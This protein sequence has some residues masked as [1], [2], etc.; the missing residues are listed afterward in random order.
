MARSVPR[1]TTILLNVI[2]TTSLLVYGFQYVPSNRAHVEKLKA[3]DFSYKLLVEDRDL[4]AYGHIVKDN[5]T[6]AYRRATITLKED[7]V[8]AGYSLSKT[9]SFTKYTKFT[10]PTIKDKVGETTAQ[11][12]AYSF[13][14]TGDIIS[15]TNKKTKQSQTM[16][17]NARITYLRVPYCEN[18]DQNTITFK[19]KA[20]EVRTVA[21]SVFMDA[22]SH[23]SIRTSILI[24]KSTEGIDHSKTSGNVVD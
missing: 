13:L 21:R 2:L 14:L 5:N 20:G 6:E 11:K 10:G 16:I 24:K 19:N 8:V 4:C 9:Q 18:P 15:R 3:S 12:V 1:H 22:L 23:L 17:V 7:H